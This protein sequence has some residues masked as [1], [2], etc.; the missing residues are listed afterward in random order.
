MIAAKSHVSPNGDEPMNASWMRAE[1]EL[2]EGYT[3]KILIG[4]LLVVLY[5]S[6]FILTPY[7]G[8][9][10]DDYNS[11]TY[12][13][14]TPNQLWE[15][16]LQALQAWP[17]GRPLIGVQKAVFGEL[18]WMLGGL[19]GVYVLGYLVLAGNALFTFAIIRHVAPLSVAFAGAVMMIVYPADASKM[20]Y[21]RTL[22]VQFVV[23][24]FLLSTWMYLKGHKAW[25]YVLIFW[26]VGVY[27]TV[28]L[29]FFFVPGLQ[30]PWR[31]QLVG[32]QIRHVLIV[33]VLLC[34]AV[35]LRMFFNSRNL[36]QADQGLGLWSVLAKSV[37]AVMLGT[38][39]SA[40]LLFL[41]LF[42]ALEQVT[43]I[44]GLVILAVSVLVYLVLISVIKSDLNGESKPEKGIFRDHKTR[45]HPF[46]WPPCVQL[47]SVGV[48]M[49][50]AAYPLFVTAARFPP[51]AKY[52]RISSPHAAAEIGVSFVVAGVFWM[53]LSHWKGRRQKQII[54]AVTA[55]YFGL[56]AGF[57]VTVQTELAKVW[58]QQKSIWKA[59]VNEAPDLE[60]DTIIV[61]N[62]AKGGWYLSRYGEVFPW[63]F[64]SILPQ[65]IT[66]E[67]DVSPKAIWVWQLKS[68]VAFAPQ[69]MPTN[70]IEIKM[71]REPTSR[72]NMQ[73]NII[74][75]EADGQY[76]FKRVTGT[77]VIQGVPIK[78][79][80][81]GPS[82]AARWIKGP[83]YQPIIEN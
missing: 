35:A 13:G 63:N 33:A 34:G 80:E 8:L 38:L 31:R 73:G 11:S 47:I 16:V 77:K 61:V 6:C 15:Q 57:Q 41:R 46:H 65:M 32:E 42:T 60:P 28:I 29:P 22:Q 82:T 26:S 67:G 49:W 4:T 68:K 62:P 70:N 9:Y 54:G 79:K 71:L 37:Q 50:L 66:L 43:W 40:E 75:L 59:I 76:R 45:Y 58:Q 17:I 25:S 83:L 3:H 74:W 64:Q 5:L 30:L 1:H 24:I 72:K 81:P 51:I 23:L 27:E 36:T 78:L 21:I 44:S 14:L 48:L 20:I 18:A 19:S 56:L 12:W 69:V 39:T 53:L 52:G 2:F 55:L 10:A 7:M